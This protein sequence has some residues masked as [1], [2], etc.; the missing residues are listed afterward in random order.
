LQTFRK[1]EGLQVQ[2]LEGMKTQGAEGL[3]ALLAG[4]Q[5]VL[6]AI[7]REKAELK[8]FLDAWEKLDPA[9]RGELRK[10]E[11]GDILDA[12]EAVAKGIQARHADWFGD[13]PGTGAQGGTAQGGQAGGAARDGR[14][15][16][17]GGQDLSQ[18]INFYRSLQ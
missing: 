2:A 16:G 10:G 8:P 11:A 4:Q 7:A 17:D 9:R 6:L 15:G 18:T 5:E 3:A 14:A 12:L 13:D 1:L